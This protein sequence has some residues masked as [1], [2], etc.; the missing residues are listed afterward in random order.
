MKGG[1]EKMENGKLRFAA[2]VRVSTESQ[3]RQGES[4]R[5]QKA[6]IE[7][8]VEAMG[9][10][11]IADPWS[12]SGQEHSTPGFEREKLD[13]LLHDASKGIFDAIIVCDASRWSRDN[14]ASKSGLKI[15]KKHGIRF[16]VGQTEFDLFQPAHSLFLG[17]SAEM[18]EFFASEQNRKSIINR[19]ARAKRGIPTSGKL[20]YGRTW[21]GKEWGIDEEKREKIQQAATR[22]L[23]GDQ[24]PKIA[25]S[26]GMNATNLWKIL[27]QR[28]GT[29]WL[30]EF[31]TPKFGIDETVSMIIPALLDQRTI[32]AIKRRAASNKTYTHGM[33]ARPYILSRMVFC[34]DCGYSMFGQTNHNERRYYRHP[35][36]RKNECDPS[37]WVN[38]EDLEEAVF[39]KLFAMVGDPAGLQ[40][41]LQRA[42]PNA[43]KVE[44]LLKQKESLEK[45]LKAIDSQKEN[46]VRSIAKGII[47][48]EDAARSMKEIKERQAACKE[49]I[50]QISRQTAGLPTKE[51][52]KAKSKLIEK[53]LTEYFDSPSRLARMTFD[54]KRKIMQTVFDGKTDQGKRLGVYVK[55]PSEPKGPITYTILGIFNMDRIAPAPWM[56]LKGKLP[57]PEEEKEMILQGDPDPATKGVSDPEQDL[58]GKCYAYHRFSIH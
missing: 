17:M 31:K 40:K 50:E 19:M 27:T 55:K 51:Q 7:R 20:P 22:Y 47:S 58:L 2:L 11:L 35:R 15:L 3:E 36:D 41:A 1:E 10:V 14:A 57:M 30:Q 49:T 13:R 53:M 29:E 38:A 34:A 39:L 16:F 23:Q 21:N 43:E 52:I 6:E 44:E 32:E 25:K 37:F 26:F 54:E 48:D 12:Y 33:K 5:T 46:I 18:N 8:S 45:E 9:G 4:L 42:I 28:C 24:I 56:D